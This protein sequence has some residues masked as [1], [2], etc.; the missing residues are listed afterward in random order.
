[1]PFLQNDLDLISDWL[2]HHLLQLN[3]TKSKYIFFSQKPI[4][5]FDSFPPLINSDSTI[6]RVS[7]FRYLGVLLTS[8]LSWSPHINAT[9]SKAHKILGMIFRHFYHHFSPATII[10]LYS[11]LV[12]P[13]LEY[14]SVVWDPSSSSLSNILEFVQLFTVK[15][16][17]QISSLSYPFHYTSILHFF[18]L[19]NAV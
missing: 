17:L 1:M 15:T 5:F 16:R 7:S 13:I 12:R 9:C 6:E 2:S 8:S 4:H 14:C 3:S 19:L 10:R 11:S 18:P